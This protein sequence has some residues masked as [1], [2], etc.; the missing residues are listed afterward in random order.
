ML[1]MEQKSTEFYQREHE[2]LLKQ[3]WRLD[4]DGCYRKPETTTMKI[5]TEFALIDVTDGRE[6]LAKV[7]TEGNRTAIVL[8]GFVQEGSG[9]IGRDDGTS[10]EFAVTVM[11]IEVGKPMKPLIDS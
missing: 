5:K 9:G 3:G 8:Y 11:G 4:S 2:R 10:R 1:G 7:C 6:E